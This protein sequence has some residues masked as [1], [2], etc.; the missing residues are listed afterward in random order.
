MRGGGVKVSCGAVSLTT[1]FLSELS[2]M[3]SN[4]GLGLASRPLPGAASGLLH[5]SS[6]VCFGVSKS[7]AC[8]SS[9]QSASWSRPNPGDWDGVASLPTSE[10]FRPSVLPSFELCCEAL[11]CLKCSSEPRAFRKAILRYFLTL[12]PIPREGSSSSSLSFTQSVVLSSTWRYPRLLPRYRFRS[13]STSSSTSLS[14][15]NSFSSSLSFSAFTIRR[16]VVSSA[17]RSTSSVVPSS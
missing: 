11:A 3:L 12:P 15:T 10:L 7:A 17:Q 14:S 13:L 16:Y 6:L 2:C 4:K 8:V 9:T 5:C 1:S